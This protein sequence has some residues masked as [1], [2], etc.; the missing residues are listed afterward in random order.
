MKYS[1]YEGYIERL[2]REE[3]YRQAGIVVPV[4]YTGGADGGEHIT[5]ESYS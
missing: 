4:V 1:S 2:R 5:A 3:Q